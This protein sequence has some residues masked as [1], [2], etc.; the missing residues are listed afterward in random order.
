[1]LHEQ[2]SYTDPLTLV[3]NDAMILDEHDNGNVDIKLFSG[4][5]IHQVKAESF[6]V[7]RP[8]DTRDNNVALPPLFS[9]CKVFLFLTP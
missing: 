5:I 6:Q 4:A 1:M 3:V 7:P 2:V 8:K 9:L